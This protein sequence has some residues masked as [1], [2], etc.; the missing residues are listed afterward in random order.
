MPKNNRNP[1]KA[2]EIPKL[3][4]NSQVVKRL[5]RVEDTVE[6]HYKPGKDFKD[7]VKGVWQGAD[8][9]KDLMYVKDFYGKVVEIKVRYVF[10]IRTSMGIWADGLLKVYI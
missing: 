7:P 10:S 9:G 8:F 6:V 4:I 3:R 2:E 5:I 1:V